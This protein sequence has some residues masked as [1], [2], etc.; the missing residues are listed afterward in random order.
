MQLFR[1]GQQHMLL[2]LFAPVGCLEAS[3]PQAR[4]GWVDYC[5]QICGDVALCRPL[6][7]MPEPMDEVVAFP[8][9]F[10][11]VRPAAVSIFHAYHF[12]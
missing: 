3:I 10:F 7:P 8:V 1:R 5:A 11:Y 4:H 12:C 2:L 6:Q 9:D